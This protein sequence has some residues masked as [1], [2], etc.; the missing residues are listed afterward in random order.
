MFY[1]V[2][3]YLYGKW[4]TWGVYED[5]DEAKDAASEHQRVYEDDDVRIVPIPKYLN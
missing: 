5:A 2:D 4:H 1:R 3:Y